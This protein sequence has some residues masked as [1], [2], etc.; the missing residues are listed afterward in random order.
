MVSTAPSPDHEGP[1][2]RNSR[3]LR[4]LGGSADARSRLRW[5]DALV[6]ANLGLARSVAARQ[7]MQRRDGFEDM[8]QVASLALIRAVEAF[9]PQ[10]RVSLSSFAVPYMR[11]ALLHEIRDRQAPVRIPRALWERRQQAA[12]LQEE[13]R[14]HGLPA[15]DRASLA[16]QLNCGE[17]QLLEI[18]TLALVAHPR[19]LDA[20]VGGSGEEA[21]ISLIERL[22]DPRSLAAPAEDPE[23]ANAD[24]AAMHRWLQAQLAQLDLQRREL[25]FGRFAERCTW[26]ELGQR[27]GIHPR[28]AQRRCD[29]SLAELRRAAA[30]WQRPRPF[31][32]ATGAS[33]RGSAAPRRGSADR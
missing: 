32:Q 12:R 6:T 3:L 11:G 23:N 10:R 27:L 16:R 33:G 13:R 17:E 4:Q 31:N 8:V 14:R 19:S 28:M 26:V 18:E 22:A 25:L 21:G 15:L 1:R 24:A 7:Q 20:P 29:A 30:A 5:R 2:A 9:D